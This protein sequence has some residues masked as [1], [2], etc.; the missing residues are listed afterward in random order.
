MQPLEMRTARL[1][2]FEL[3]FDLP[4]GPG[5][6]GVANVAPRPGERVWGVAY[7]VTVAQSERRAGSRDASRR[8]VIW[9]FC[10][11]ALAV[12]VCRAEPR[13]AATR[14]TAS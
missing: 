2:E 8:A 11:R 7:R 13:T 1:D 6:R 3:R 10:S 5:E 14:P 12:D 4:V 9:A